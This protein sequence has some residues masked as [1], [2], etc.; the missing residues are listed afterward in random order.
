MLFDGNVY[1]AE[2]LGTAGAGLEVVAVVFVDQ[3]RWVPLWT[4]WGGREDGEE[5]RR[6]PTEGAVVL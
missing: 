4:G 6:E 3:T 2:A 5:A 1:H